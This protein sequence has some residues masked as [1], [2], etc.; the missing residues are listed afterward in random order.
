VRETNE[1]ELK[2]TAP[3]EFESVEGLGEPIEDRSFT[4]TYYDTPERALARAG[5]TLRPARGY[6]AVLR[7][8]DEGKA[9]ACRVIWRTT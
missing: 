5:V 7:R 9:H 6:V 8:T 3:D 4:T 2:L 1:R